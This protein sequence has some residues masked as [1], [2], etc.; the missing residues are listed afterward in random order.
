MLDASHSD[1][2]DNDLDT[3]LGERYYEGSKELEIK[4]TNE[5]V[6][7]IGRAIENRFRQGGGLAHRDAHAFDNGCVRAIFRVDE[8]LD[9]SLRHG[10]FVPG[11]EYR[12]WIRFSNGNSEPRPAWF[13]DARGMAI[14]L[15]GVS[16]AKLLD[17]EKNTQDFILI[18]HPTF[19]VDDLRRYKATLVEFLKGGYIDQYVVSLLKL[20]FPSE[21]WLALRANFNLMVNP[22]FQ[23]YWSMTPYR[24]GV[25]PDKKFAVKYTAKPRVDG[26][27]GF[28][29]RQI[30]RL[31]WNFSLKEEMNNKLAGNEV[32]F[33]FYIQPYVDERRTPI[34]DSKVKWTEDVSKPQHVAKIIIPM[35]DCISPEQDLFC[36]NLSFSPWHSLPEHKP[37][38]LVNRVRKVAYRE[39]S[40]LRHKL[41]GMPRR[42]PT[43]DEMF[44]SHGY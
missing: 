9:P 25:D 3:A 14:K 5:I 18:S 32:W 28:L 20:R 42:E 40:E 33:D 8:D 16:G 22:L 17:D 6:E 34:E 23:Q 38:G 15:P 31:E 13:F 35:Q 24:L 36:E 11:R 37:L 29:S 2:P 12:T 41:N 39:I 21:F 1:D 43:G 27:P 30:T 44:D 19:F 10:V 7:A 26:M 4:Y